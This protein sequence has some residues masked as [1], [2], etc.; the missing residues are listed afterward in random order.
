[1]RATTRCLVV[2]IAISSW[3]AISN[4]CAISA[5]ATKAK[6]AQ[7]EC[8]FHS[9]PAKPQPKPAAT[10][11]CKVLRAIAITPSKSVAPAVVDFSFGEL[12]VL[13]PQKISFAQTTLDTGPPGKTLFAELSR[14][15][16]AH[17]PPFLS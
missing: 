3:F 15:S 16:R 17:A 1:M 4:H 12:I 14:G 5:A 11:C 13:A 7:S 6:T 2:A 9:K 8:P 10:E